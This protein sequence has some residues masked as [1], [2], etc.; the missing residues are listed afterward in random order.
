MASDSRRL[1]LCVES[2]PAAW[3][4]SSL[5]TFIGEH[6]ATLQ[7]T[8]FVYTKAHV[9]LRNLATYEDALRFFERERP[10]GGVASF[11]VDTLSYKT[12]E[13]AADDAANAHVYRLRILQSQ[14]RLAAMLGTV[15]YADPQR[16]V[17]LQRLLRRLA[18]YGV[19]GLEAQ[20]PLIQRH[21]AA[22]ARDINQEKTRIV[23]EYNS[24][25]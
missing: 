3:K 22:L 16:V 15:H 24:I 10:A 21:V 23:R 8:V 25:K 12:R 18:E 2:T 20:R 7:R 6:D 11:F 17:G 4:P 5:R 13:W 14:E 9:Q 1:I 19:V